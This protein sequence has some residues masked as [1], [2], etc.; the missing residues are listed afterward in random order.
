MI[1]M[2]LGHDPYLYM[3]MINKKLN[4]VTE[5]RKKGEDEFKGGMNKKLYVWA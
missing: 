3:D 2:V 5:I 4:R 1:K